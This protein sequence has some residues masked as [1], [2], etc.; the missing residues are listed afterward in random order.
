M[1]GAMTANTAGSEGARQMLRHAVATLAYRA[2]KV[3]RDFPR[4]AVETHASPVTRT[5]LALV[6]HLGDLMEWAV[7]MA[8]GVNRW[9]AEP[10]GTWEHMTGRFFAGLADLDAVLSHPPPE[11][12]AAETIFQGPVADALTHVGQLAILRGIGG[13]AVRP[14]SYA[15]AEIEVGRVGQEQAAPRAEFDGDASPPPPR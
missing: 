6:A 14:E 13:K 15:R 1:T 2:A 10:H 11:T 9:R 5:P 7:G 12:L 4:D 8:R 3:L